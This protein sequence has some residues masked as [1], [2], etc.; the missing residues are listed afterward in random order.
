[1]AKESSSGRSATHGHC[2]SRVST[3]C[4]S[5]V[6]QPKRC[7]CRKRARAIILLTQSQMVYSPQSRD[8]RSEKRYGGGQAN[9]LYIFDLKSYATKQ[10]TEGPRPT[11]DP[12]WIGDTIYFNSDRDGHFNLYAYNVPSVRPLR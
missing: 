10:I 2:R 7:Q 1:M 5:K 11:R 9:S 12:M 4:R 6:D 8:F 3:R